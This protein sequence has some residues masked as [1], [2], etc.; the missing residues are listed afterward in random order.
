MK[1]RIDIDR[2]PVSSEEILARRNFNQLMTNAQLI[3]KPFYKSNWFISTVSVATL[4]TVA[5]VVY[6]NTGSPSP[7]ASTSAT[8][9]SDSTSTEMLAYAED[10]PCIKPPIK[11]A[12][13][14]F[15]TYTIDNQEGACFVHETGSVVSIPKN[16]IVD[17]NGNPVQGKVEIRYREFHDQADILLSGIPMTYDSAGVKRQFESAGMI[18]IHGYQN[19]NPV[20][21]DAKNPIKVEMASRYPGTHYNMYD[22]DTVSKN[23]VYKGKDQVREIAQEKLNSN[24]PAI[25]KEIEQKVNADPAIAQQKQKVEQAEKQIAQLEKKKPTEP[26]KVDPKKYNFNLDVDYNDFPELKAFGNVRFEVGPE[27]RNFSPDWYDVEWDNISLN[28]NVP[29]K[30]YKI[31]LSKGNTKKEVIVYPVYEGM[32]YTQAMQKFNTGLKQYQNNLDQKKKEEVQLE[33]ELQQM[34]QSKKKEFLKEKQHEFELAQQSQQLKV[35]DY[36]LMRQQENRRIQS[37]RSLR[38]YGLIEVN[39]RVENLSSSTLSSKSVVFRTFDVSGFGV[40][41]SDCGRDIGGN[42]VLAASFTDQ[43]TGTP[44]IPAETYV[45]ELD[46]NLVYG[47]SQQELSALRYDPNQRSMLVVMTRTGKVGWFS[48]DRLKGITKQKGKVTFDLEMSKNE[49]RSESQLRKLLF[50]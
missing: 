13:K 33:S 7:D 22:L 41:N 15:T 12:E 37:E 3:Q 43:S 32:G 24:D 36:E 11:G 47:F 9:T 40:K 1:P 29:G 49:I 6:M 2:E 26:Q 21:V 8:T 28:E 48:A 4:A 35:N 19:G 5:A 44:V 18:E 17:A 27:S 34:I 10:S 50:D 16:S 23:W 31:I 39:G 30:N 25:K 42:V 20:Q 14:P 45:V 38:E 46:R